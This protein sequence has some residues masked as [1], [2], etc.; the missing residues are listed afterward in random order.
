M[1]LETIKRWTVF[2]GDRNGVPCCRRAVA[3]RTPT[4]DGMTVLGL[5]MYQKRLVFWLPCMGELAGTSPQCYW[6]P[7]RLKIGL[8]RACMQCTTW[9]NTTF[10]TDRIISSHAL[11]TRRLA[12][13]REIRD[14]GQYIRLSVCRRKEYISPAFQ[15]KL[16]TVTPSSLAWSRDQQ[17]GK[18]ESL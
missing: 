11:T 9:T 1:A 6:R 8:Y 3:E 14:I 12:W 17:K 2:D 13:C 10:I 16:I 5:I 18:S 15:S 7:E 4:N